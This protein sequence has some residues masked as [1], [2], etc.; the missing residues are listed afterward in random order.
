MLV[1]LTT[2]IKYQEG[3]GKQDNSIPDARQAH[4]E[5]CKH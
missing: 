1:P 5:S 2:Q 3:V 4:S